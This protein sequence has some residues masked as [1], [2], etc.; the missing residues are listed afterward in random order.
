MVQIVEN[1]ADIGGTVS[2]PTLPG[3][4]PDHV[5]VR[6]DVDTVE[7]VEGFPNLL[8]DRAGQSID[9]QIRLDGP[10]DLRAGQRIGL[11]ARLAAPGGAILAD[12]RTLRLE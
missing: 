6:I 1:W 5:G 7:P 2:G 4:R 3:T 8:A 12:T 10:L 11:R 9:V